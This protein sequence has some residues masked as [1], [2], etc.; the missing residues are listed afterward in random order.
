MTASGVSDLAVA[1][2]HRGKGVARG[3]MDAIKAEG[4]EGERPNEP[5]GGRNGAGGG[6]GDSARGTR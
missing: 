1:A 2:E 6:H 4:K 3:L 5:E